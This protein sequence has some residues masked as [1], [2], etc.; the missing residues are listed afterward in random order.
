MRCVRT[1]FLSLP[2]SP[3]TIT[4]KAYCLF[5]VSGID[6]TS[7][8]CT[9][10]GVLV[11]EQAELGSETALERPT[12][13]T[14]CHCCSPEHPHAPTRTDI[15]PRAR[16]RDTVGHRA[17]PRSATIARAVEVRP[18][19]RTPTSCDHKC[20]CEQRS[21]TTLLQTATA[22]ATRCVAGLVGDGGA[23][24]APVELDDKRVRRDGE[25]PQACRDVRESSSRHRRPHRSYFRLCFCIPSSPG[26]RALGLL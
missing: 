22:V 24:M 7:S 20:A 11:I 8:P 5:E 26:R 13:L 4:S 21:C 9:A 23:R 10:L 1:A 16:R 3:R 6:P 25:L 17:V 15:T 12:T 19:R 14:R 2:A 18:N